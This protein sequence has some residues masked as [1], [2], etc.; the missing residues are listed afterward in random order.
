MFRHRARRARAAGARAGSTAG[1]TPTGLGHCRC[2]LRDHRCRAYEFRERRA[3]TIEL[4]RTRRRGARARRTRVAFATR[5][6]SRHRGGVARVASGVA[7]AHVCEI[8]ESILHA[9]AAGRGRRVTIAMARRDIP[10]AALVLAAAGMSSVLARIY[11]ARGFTSLAELDHGFSALPSP[12]GLR[13]IGAAAER[14]SRAICAREKIVIV[15]DYDADGATACAVG[16]RGLRMMGADI[17]FIVPNR[18]EFGYGLTP[19]IVA[20]AAQMQP[21]LLVTVDNGIASVDGVE[22]ATKRGI[23]V[24]ITDH[25]LPG[26]VL[27]APAIIVNPNQPGCAFPSKHVAGVG[28]MFYVLLATRAAAD[29]GRVQR[30]RRAE[31]GRPGRPGRAWHGGRRGA[32]DHEPDLRRARSRAHPR[33]ACA[34]RGACAV[35]RGR[36][37]CA[38]GDGIRPGF[39]AAR[40]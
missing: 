16:V 26:A 32:L 12:D 22:A 37:R 14:L 34:A 18:F 4:A 13:D 20:L 7:D 35:R 31:P 2:G 17:G 25:H 8:R 21:R 27:P 15:A 23:D 39:V 33:R 38:A 40:A 6:W 9:A 36:P 28:V 19:E 3:T 10:P 24:L 29:P 30:P 11:A 5:R 1:A